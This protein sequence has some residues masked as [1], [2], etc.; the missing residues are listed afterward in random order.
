MFAKFLPQSFSLGSSQKRASC[1][2]SDLNSASKKGAHSWEEA[3]GFPVAV[4]KVN[5]TKRLGMELMIKLSS[6]L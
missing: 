6:S 1:S 2:L 3:S 5:S 4:S